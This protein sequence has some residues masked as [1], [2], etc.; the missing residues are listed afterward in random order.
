M[1]SAVGGRRSDARGRGQDA[2]TSTLARLV[3]PSRFSNFQDPVGLLRRAFASGS[4]AARLMIV[5]EI[6]ALALIPLDLGLGLYEER[7]LERATDRSPQPP[8]VLIVG[9]PR[10]GTTLAYQLL[11]HYLPFSYLDNASSMFPHAPITV[12][13]ALSRLPN[14]A[15]VDTSSYYG[16][17]AGLRAPNDGFHVW[18][19]WLG[20][21]RYHA[22]STLAPETS[23][24]M[25]QFFRAWFG[26]F[27]QPFLNKNNRN[28]LCLGALTSE[29]DNVTALFVKRDPFFVAQSL[30][31]A[32][33]DVQGSRSIGWGALAD[34]SAP[35]QGSALD[36]VAEQTH[37]V[38]TQMAVAKAALSPEQYMEIDYEALCADPRGLITT[39][40]T[41]IWGDSLSPRAS[42]DSIVPLR[43]RDT[44]RLPEHEALHL[45]DRINQ[46][47]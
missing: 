28:S 13:Q 31:K 46:W 3:R 21:D 2:S 11:A 25:R 22:P 45:A 19:R 18:N 4:R 29:L 8:I 20:E 5:R 38:F 43:H 34:H 26:A 12:T 24:S 37:R 16:N 7:I 15:P 6:A 33:E 32:R 17:A 1:V 30:L 9:P 27:P 42:L 36:D 39:L 23:D 44:V 47:R 35:V 40:G 10:S 41:R 14:R